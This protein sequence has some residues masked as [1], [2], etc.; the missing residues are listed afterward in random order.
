MRSSSV[1]L[2][3][4][5]STKTRG[6]E[7]RSGDLSRWVLRLMW[8]IESKMVP[9]Y[10]HRSVYIETRVDASQPE[11]GEETKTQLWNRYRS[12]LC[13]LD[14]FRSNSSW[15]SC[16]FQFQIRLRVFFG[17]VKISAPHTLK[18]DWSVL[19]GLR[20]ETGGQMFGSDICLTCS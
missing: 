2:S 5:R 16:L 6:S 18:R 19:L 17:P 4:H 14:R 9:F 8:S 7:P 20:A 3:L 10:S 11:T 1:A 15:Y 12:G 13:L